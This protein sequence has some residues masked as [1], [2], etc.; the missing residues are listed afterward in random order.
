MPWTTS[1]K[2][3][4][5]FIEKTY[6]GEIEVLDSNLIDF[7]INFETIAE[8]LEKAKPFYSPFLVNLVGEML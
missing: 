1:C 6:L 8:A 2:A 7:E 4:S 5:L 3:S